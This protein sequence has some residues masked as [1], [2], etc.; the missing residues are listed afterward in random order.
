M[1]VEPLRTNLSSPGIIRIVHRQR[2]PRPVG[3]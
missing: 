3:K 1:P 2:Q